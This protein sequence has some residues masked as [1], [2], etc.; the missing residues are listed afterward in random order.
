MERVEYG[1]RL[2]SEGTRGRF[3]PVDVSHR[4]TASESET[5]IGSTFSEDDGDVSRARICGSALCTRAIA[6]MSTTGG[7]PDTS[8]FTSIRDRASATGL[9]HPS[10]CRI[11]EVYWDM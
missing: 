6:G 4:I 2:Q 3:A 9:S 10:I 5:G 1:A 8:A 7:R 11:A